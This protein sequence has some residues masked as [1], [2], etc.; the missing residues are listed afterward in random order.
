MSHDFHVCNFVDAVRITAQSGNGGAGLV[1]FR[2]EKYIPKG[3]PDGGDGGDGGNVII[4]ASPHERTLK[5]LRYQ[6]LYRAKNGDRGLSRKKHGKNGEDVVIS[7]PVSTVVRNA[8]DKSMVSRFSAE[9]DSI[10]LLRGGMGGRGNV[11]F[12]NSVCQTPSYAQKGKTG[13]V[14]DFV[15]ELE[16]CSDASF[17]GMPNVGK[18][19]LLKVLTNAN[20]RIGNY[21]FTTLIPNMGTL[22]VRHGEF[23]LSDIPG[24]VK[25][26]ADGRGLGLH[27]LRH[28]KRSGV[29]F[30]VLDGSVSSEITTVQQYTT[31]W[32]EL[33]KYSDITNAECDVVGLAQKPSCV[34]I[35]KIDDSPYVHNSKKCVDTFLTALSKFDLRRAEYTREYRAA[36][37]DAMRVVCVS[38]HMMYGIDALKELLFTAV[39]ETRS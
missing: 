5:K 24:I 19:T 25:G 13:L 21:P 30:Y 18:S 38:A 37:I 10:I 12:K 33:V 4:V 28:V 35:S 3:G 26:A 2:R 32:S 15:F 9:G 20:P 11:H 39:E 17:I 36:C 8:Y 23:I 22:V 34:V 29:I 27:F 7:V 6:S 14:R 16:L 31:L 1:S